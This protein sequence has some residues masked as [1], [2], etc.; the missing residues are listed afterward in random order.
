[1]NAL[2]PLARPLT[3]IEC[4]THRGFRTSLGKG[5]PH[6]ILRKD[7]GFALLEG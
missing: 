1:M 6:P 4:E 3:V 7:A 2:R 5:T